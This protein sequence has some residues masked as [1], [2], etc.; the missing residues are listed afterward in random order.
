MQTVKIDVLAGLFD[1]TERQTR[2][3]LKEAGARPVSRGEWPLVASVRAVFRKTREARVST[4]V[5]KA[6]TR[7]I[8]AVALKH[9]IAN[10]RAERHLVPRE[11]VDY[12]VDYVMGVVV[13]ELSGLP[14]RITRDVP[15]RRK[16]EDEIFKSRHRMAEAVS[17]SARIL[18]E[19]SELPYSSSADD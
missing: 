3:V 18:A 19:G 9:E 1:L 11:D 10:K 8:E 2:N 14:A 13:E 16:I 4:E 6:R 5:S 7:Q 12:A 17:T 15:L